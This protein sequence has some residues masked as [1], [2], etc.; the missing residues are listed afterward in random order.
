MNRSLFPVLWLAVV[1]A[2][3]DPRVFVCFFKDA[4]FW[5]DRHC[6]EYSTTSNSCYTMHEGW[7][8]DVSS[9]LTSRTGI[10]T[11]TK[12]DMYTRDRCEGKKY[13][14]NTNLSPCKGENFE[15][16]DGLNDNSQSF[17]IHDG[18]FEVNYPICFHDGAN[19]TGN[20]TCSVHYDDICYPIDKSI[21]GNVASISVSPSERELLPFELEVFEGTKCSLKSWTLGQRSDGISPHNL[22][23]IQGLDSKIV[24]FK[25]KTNTRGNAPEVKR[26][27]ITEDGKLWTRMSDDKTETRNWFPWL[28]AMRMSGQTSSYCTATAVSD[29]WILTSAKC[30]PENASASEILSS[31]DDLNPFYRGFASVS[32]I[33][34]CITHPDYQPGNPSFDVAVC[35]T[36]TRMAGTPV[37]LPDSGADFTNATAWIAGF[38]GDETFR[39]T[40]QH[41]I[42]VLNNSACASDSPPNSRQIICG[43]HMTAKDCGMHSSLPLVVRSHKFVRLPLESYYRFES[44]DYFTIIGIHSHDSETCKQKESLSRFTSVAHIKQWI[45]T[46]TS[47]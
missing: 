41:S 30:V 35:R 5:M 25:V 37:F 1:T 47:L 36:K 27:L 14:V 7:K 33:D 8:E 45:T 21:R 9:L 13:E 42:K 40:E 18:D 22:T 39:E 15:S 16:C 26:A 28:V 32:Q 3:S 12:I 10:R 31:D 20:K 24:S 38:E 11:Q 44:M 34:R 17:I 6:R 19:Y 43:R 23:S 46:T 2:A 4:D 29:H